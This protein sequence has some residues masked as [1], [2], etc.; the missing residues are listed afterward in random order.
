MTV[1]PSIAATLSN[2]ESAMGA[3]RAALDGLSPELDR[4]AAT[5][6]GMEGR[7]IVAGMGKS[8]HVGRKLAATFASTGTP[9][10][11][12][13]PAEASHGDLGMIGPGDAILMLSWSGETR[14][15]S[16]MLAYAKRFGVPTIAIT[17]AGEGTLARRA[18]VA[19]V[20]PR[21][22]EAC[23][24][25]LAPTT[26]TLMQLAVGDALA[27]ALLTEKGFTAEAFRDVHPGGKLGAALLPISEVML[28]G[29][30]LPL[31]S[32]DASLMRVLTEVG[33]KSVGIAGLV[34]G[35]GALSGVITDGDIRR[36]LAARAESRMADVLT[37]PASAVMT[38]APFCLAPDRLASSALG[39][40][41]SRRISAAFVVE[42]ERPVGLVTLLD[43]L[44]VGVA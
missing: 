36:H 41:Q 44:R 35:E 37:G 17:G 11:F 38:R 5:L 21:L 23:P 22:E 4:A 25:S 8:G 6:L 18:D 9:A 2:Y 28:T 20:L 15:L 40:L 30:R 32:E 34:D 33:R 42:D 31:L 16:D 29:E 39:E 13:H 1:L 10:H 19:L 14:E 27:I 7:L 26:S 24:L 12:V 3:M 43:L